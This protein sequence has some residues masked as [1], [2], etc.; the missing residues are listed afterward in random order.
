ML[1]LFKTEREL[2]RLEKSGRLFS[3]RFSGQVFA[4]A[5]DDLGDLVKYLKTEAVAQRGYE[6]AEAAWADVQSA[7]KDR[8]G[9][10]EIFGMAPFWFVDC[11][12]WVPSAFLAWTGLH[13]WLAANLKTER[14][15]MAASFSREQLIV[16][17]ADSVEFHDRLSHAREAPVESPL[18]P[19]PF[20]LRPEEQPLAVEKIELQMGQQVT[21]TPEDKGLHILE[22]DLRD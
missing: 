11:R 10:L 3:Y 7:F 9:Q 14:P 1:S 2:G 21:L 18:F 13:A 8:E 15:L 22:F 17:F 20:I 12:S 5:A 6:N 19:L 16:G 4:V